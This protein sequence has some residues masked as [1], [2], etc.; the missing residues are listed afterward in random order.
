MFCRFF[1]VL[2]RPAMQCEIAHEIKTECAFFFCVY[3]VNDENKSNKSIYRSV[4]NWKTVCRHF[5]YWWAIQRWM[6]C[7]ETK[8]IRN[9]LITLSFLYSNI[10]QNMQPLCSA[11]EYM[12]CRF[13]VLS[14]SGGGG[15]SFIFRENQI[16]PSLSTF[17]CGRLPEPHLIRMWPLRWSLN[18]E[19]QLWYDRIC[20]WNLMG[21][22]YG[23]CESFAPDIQF[24]RR[25]RPVI[26]CQYKRNVDE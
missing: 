25:R 21:L 9:V 19:I 6:A 22:K 10:I 23:K 12:K 24:T 14:S 1:S 2:P 7:T 11:Y 20:H 4:I 18:F 26:Q 3:S 13:V 15:T 16:S 8:S 17:F 5:A